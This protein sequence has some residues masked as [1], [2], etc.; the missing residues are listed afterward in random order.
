MASTAKVV[1]NN[2]T[3]VVEKNGNEELATMNFHSKI[4]GAL[5]LDYSLVTD[6]TFE[7]NSIEFYHRGVFLDDPIVSTKV[8]TS[9][10]LF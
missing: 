9:I 7:S 3:N 8:S 2:L 6:P 5:T 1:C 10:E 4:K